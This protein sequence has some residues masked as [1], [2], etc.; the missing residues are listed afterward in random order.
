M[1]QEIRQQNENLWSFILQG[2]EYC[3]Y[4]N[5]SEIEI[6]EYTELPGG[7]QKMKGEGQQEIVE[8]FRNFI[9]QRK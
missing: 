7:Y 9:W 1:I 3:I 2:K 6:Y 4:K 8:Y 5:G